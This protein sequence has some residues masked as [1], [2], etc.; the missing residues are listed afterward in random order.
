MVKGVLAAGTNERSAIGNRDKIFIMLDLHSRP[1]CWSGLYWCNLK[2]HDR[3]KLHDAM[4]LGPC[5]TVLSCKI[6]L[7]L[8]TVVGDTSSETA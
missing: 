7:L 3:S 8:P 1:I 4:E 5:D 6:Q 2:S